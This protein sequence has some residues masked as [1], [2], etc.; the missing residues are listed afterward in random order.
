MFAQKEA[1]H[2][3]EKL[4]KFVTFTLWIIEKKKIQKK[5]ILAMDETAMWSDMVG[6]TTVDLKGARSVPLKTTGHE[7]SQ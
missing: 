7:K 4:L 2:F 5:N 1:R 6:S 3:T